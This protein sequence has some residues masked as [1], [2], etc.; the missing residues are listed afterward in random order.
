[1]LARFRPYTGARLRAL[2]PFVLMGLAACTGP[3][4]PDVVGIPIW[5]LGG[6]ALGT[7]W[8]VKYAE[9]EAAEAEVKAAVDEALRA[10]DEAMSTWRS[11]SELSRLRAIDGPMVVS[12]STHEVVASALEVASASGGAFDPTVQALV[13][14]WGFQGARRQDL[15]SEEALEA[16]RAQVGWE[17]VRLGRNDDGQPWIDDG[18]T[19][20]DLSA[21]AKGYAV[22]RVS[23]ALSRLGLANHMVEVGGEV[24]AHGG[25]PSGAGWRL[26]IDRPEP[27]GLP[28][29]RLE[30]VVRL[31]NSA[32]ATS[33]NYRNAYEIDGK[34]VVHTFDP[35][36][37]RPVESPVASA[38]VVAPDC[39]TADAWA[40][41]LMVLGPDVGMRLVEARPDM[42]ALLLVAEGD[43]FRSVESSGMADFLVRP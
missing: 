43:Q 31:T 15:P 41:A 19:S 36:V 26:G 1:M 18:G 37:G 4:E 6:S 21:I 24:R 14:L 32:L 33:G 22:D 38:T 20:L 40:T 34:R 3:E 27:G 29:H 13:E 10:V 7:T 17:R 11:D 16:A 25:G 8:T 30:A 42:E 2:L 39:T 5:Q 23:H 12:E 28:G 9:K 35:R